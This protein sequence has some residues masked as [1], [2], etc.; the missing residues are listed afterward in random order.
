MNCATSI[1]STTPVFFGN[2]VDK[3]VQDYRD[4]K[5]WLKKHGAGLDL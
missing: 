2:E 3:V 5:R 1:T 4:R